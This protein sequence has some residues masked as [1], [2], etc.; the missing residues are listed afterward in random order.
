MKKIS[1]I[2][3]L[4]NIKLFGAF[5]CLLFILS[6]SLIVFDYPPNM[7]NIPNINGLANEFLE[8]HQLI[9]HITLIFL[10]FSIFTKNFTIYHLY[11]ITI[12]GSTIFSFRILVAPFA[13]EATFPKVEAVV[14]FPKKAPKSEVPIEIIASVVVVFA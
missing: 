6:N 9:F 13:L 10:I 11:F 14:V 4:N 2:L 7:S 12:I 3:N 1:H 8:S 5:L